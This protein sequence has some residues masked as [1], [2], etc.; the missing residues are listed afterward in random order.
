MPLGALPARQTPHIDGRHV[1]GPVPV[2]R[3]SRRA[4]GERA[5][6]RGA[7]HRAGAP[8]TD[9]L[10]RAARRPPPERIRAGVRGAARLAHRLHRLGRHRDRADGARGAVRRRPLYAAG[11]RAGRR[12]AVRHRAPGRDAARPLD[13]AESRRRRPPRLRSLAAHGRGRGAIEQGLRRGRRHAGG[14]RARPDRRHLERPPGAAARRGHAAR[15]AL[16]RRGGRGEA[17]A[18]PRGGREAARRRAGGVRS[19]RGRL[20]VQHPRRRRGPHAA[21]ARLRDHSEGG[22]AFALRRRP[23]ALERRPPLPRSARRHAR[24]GA[25]FVRAL[26][27]LGKDK[28]TVRL[29][30]ATAADALARLVSSARRQGRA[31]RRPDRA[32]EGGEERDRDCRRARG[33][34]PRRRRRRALPRLARPRSAERQAQRDR[35]G[36]GARKLPARHRPAQGYFLPDHRRR[37]ARRRHR[38][39][40]RDDRDQPRASRPANCS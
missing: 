25:D 38:A 8:R 16:R 7:A 20:G 9:R 11:A 23:Q 30:Q 12:R 31:R 6:R 3:G 26:G 32:D 24:A 27:A 13:R 22:P 29:D 4:R 33:A 14:G 5:A 37:R 40:S 15:P 2:V 18:H 19:A 35:R 21:A 1:R 36:R 10:H 17:R 39:L 34:C 28:K